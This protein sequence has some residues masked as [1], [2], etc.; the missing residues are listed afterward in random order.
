MKNVFW[1][2]FL[3]AV[4]ANAQTPVLPDTLET[5]I[6]HLHEVVITGTRTPKLVK[7]SPVL[8]RVIT[9]RDIQKLNPANFRSLL[10]AELPG[11]EFTSNANVPNIN[12]QGLDGNYVLFLLDGE[13]IAGETRNNIDYD[14]LN[15][16]NIERVEIVK[17]ALSTLYGSNAMGGVIN[18]ITHKNARRLNLNARAGSHGEQ[19]YALNAG[20]RHKK[21]S[22]YTSGL[23][24]TSRNYILEDRAYLERIYPDK[25]VTDAVLRKKEVEGG[26]ALNLEQK[27]SYRFSDRLTTE[28]K[29]TYLQRERFNA[30]AE[31]TVMHNLY[32]S[33]NALVR[34]SFQLNLKNRL[35]LS[36]N[37]S[38]YN[39]FNFYHR[40]DL[41]EKDYTH[42][43]HNLRL[44][45][46]NQL[47]SR[48]M[49]TSGLEYLSESL[50]TYMFQ[51]G[52]NLS[53]DSYTLYTQHDY[54]PTT[55]L[56]LLTGMRW[57]KHSNYGGNL[58][59]SFSARY[60]LSEPISL[61]A[62]YAW[63]F[64]SPSLKELYTNWDHLGMFQIIG[65]P[66]LKPEKSR[67]LS[68]TAD[69]T[70]GK[71]YGSVNVFRH[72]IREKMSL[73]WN[74]ANDTVYYFN[75]DRL[76][77]KGIELN[78]AFI[79][80]KGGKVQVGYTFTHD[81]RKTDHQNVSYTRPHTLVF[82]ADYTWGKDHH[83]TVVSLNGKYLSGTS[84]YTEDQSGEFY[85]IRYP[86]YSIWRVQASR[87]YRD[88]L[89]LSAGIDNIWNYTP[90]VNSFYSSGSSGRTFFVTLN[91]DLTGLLFSN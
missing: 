26:K 34:N 1:F 75:A 4:G 51:T 10:E 29:G 82:K 54:T 32:H 5:D 74:A 47:T 83:R 91:M 2:I 55:R 90:E 30:G 88:Y 28:V 78:T 45:S 13:R 71:M 40:I 17:G 70:R 66:D 61:R 59:P 24:K 63:G 72:H 81:G 67:T 84:V 33:Y 44:I 57:D 39:K 7:D 58:S 53:A 14:L 52:E 21:L 38:T 23:W 50:S 85:F 27:L 64:R 35:D 68:F 80:L 87:S 43:L 11:L 49:L 8:T 79:P 15:P 60:T 16:N 62:S 3:T 56:N 25:V 37:F 73:L 20:I 46:N 6:L 19:Q 41:K 48:Q 9:A 36:Y 77:L 31:G 22:S 18:I 42:R 12:L 76:V 89:T 86:G 69:Y 65:N